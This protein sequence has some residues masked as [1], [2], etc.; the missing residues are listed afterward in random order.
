MWVA[1][2]APAKTPEADRRQAVR[3]DRRDAEGPD[4]QER[5]DDLLVEPVGSPRRSSTVSSRSSWRSTRTSSRRPISARG[6]SAGR[7]GKGSA[8]HAAQRRAHPHDHCGSLPRPR[9]SRTCCCVRKREKRSTMLSCSGEER[10]AVAD[11]L[12][13]QLDAGIDIVSDGEQAPSASPCMSATHDWVRRRSDPA[14]AAHHEPV[15]AVRALPPSAVPG[16]RNRIGQSAPRRSGRCAT[17]VPRRR[18]ANATCS[19]TRSVKA[20]A[21]PPKRS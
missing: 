21:S 20:R 1:V 12:A 9:T 7:A 18:A 15:S 4:H 5:Y 14:D 13:R 19:G 10:A 8:A 11:V 3:C 16:R 6:V 2:F 17:S